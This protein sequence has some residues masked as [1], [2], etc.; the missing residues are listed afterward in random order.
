M[1]Q[2]V[3]LVRPDAAAPG[4]GEI[5]FHV[6]GRGGQHR[7]ART[8]QRHLRGRGEHDRTVRV[9][10]LGTSLQD[11]DQRGPRL[12]EVVHR[13]GVVP[14][15]A[16]IGR[17]RLQRREPPDGLVGIGLAAR[18]RVLRHAPDALHRRVDGLA[19]D[20]RHVRP[21]PRHRDR[22]HADAEALA[23]GEVAV[24]ARDGAED[25]D[26]LLLRPR[27]R[28]AGHALQQRVDEHVVH[29]RE[30][31]IVGDH[32]LLRRRAEHRREQRAG[33]GQALEVAVIARVGAVLGGGVPVAGQRQHLGGEVEL[34]GGGLAAGHVELEALRFQGFVLAA[35]AGAQL[36]Q[37]FRRQGGQRRHGIPRG[38]AE[39]AFEPAAEPGSRPSRRK[40]V[41]ERRVA[42]PHCGASVTFAG[43]K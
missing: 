19:F 10:G 2:L 15:D 40:G 11:V 7:E 26:R 9:S 39:A 37:G 34:I 38:G 22:D 17:R 4:L 27:P 25:R 23:Q 20:R 12:G 18:V 8:R 36:R 1:A 5:P 6:R 42:H 43:A 16:E 24:I 32:D 13:V 30:A 35:Q 14:Q 31:R 41:G 21:L 3:Q 28:A 33:L 29:Q